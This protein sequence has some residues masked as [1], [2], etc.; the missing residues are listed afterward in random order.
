MRLNTTMPD[1]NTPAVSRG[2]GRTDGKRGIVAAAILLGSVACY[3][4]VLPLIQSMIIPRAP[5]GANGPWVVRPEGPL[6]IC[7]A[8]VLACVTVPFLAGPLKRKWDNEDAASGSR[9]DPLA[10]RPVK[11]ALFVLK[12]IVLL[13][14]WGAG[15][16]FYLLSWET[17]G[18]DGMKEHLPWATLRHPFQDVASL[19]TIPEGLRSDT[20]GKD[21]PWYAVKLRSGRTMTWS[22][23][24]EGM[25][26]DELAAMTTFVAQ[27]SGMAWGFRGD[28]RRAR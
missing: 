21:G 3:W 5:G 18:P 25:T 8:A 7:A 19:E 6:R 12:A 14:V 4:L 20:L 9:Y 28:A 11:R 27:R 2:F 24:N 10:G 23:D 15:L 16:M 13:T 1:T 22:L 26:R 17:I